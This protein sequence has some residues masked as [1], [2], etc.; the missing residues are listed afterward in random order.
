MHNY[1]LFDCETGGLSPKENPITEIAFLVYDSVDFKEA[2]RYDT[3]VQPYHNLKLDPKAMEITG[4]TKQQLDSGCDFEELVEIII[5]IAKKFTIVKG[6]WKVKPIFVGHNIADFD[7]GFL[8]YI[9][10]ACDKNLW[11][12]YQRYMEDTLLLC[13]TKWE[14]EYQKFNLTS[15]CKYAGIEIIDAHRALNDVEPNKELHK[16]LVDTLRSKNVNLADSKEEVN[17]FRKTFQF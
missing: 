5:M 8:E 3:F 17:S 7:I 15:C 11:D 2:F 9:F 16:Y 10:N 14:G 13:R 12:Y 4:I 1:V 6:K